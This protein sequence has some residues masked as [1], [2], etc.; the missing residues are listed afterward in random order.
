MVVEKKKDIGNL[1]IKNELHSIYSKGFILLKTKK[2][3]KENNLP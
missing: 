2:T 3:I 1:S